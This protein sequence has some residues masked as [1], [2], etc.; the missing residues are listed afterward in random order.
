M[1]IPSEI[2]TI[3]ISEKAYIGSV[4]HKSSYYHKF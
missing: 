4:A 1:V 2:R 3:D